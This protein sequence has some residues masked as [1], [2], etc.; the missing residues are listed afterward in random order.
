MN[1]LN[2]LTIYLTSIRLLND[3][4][5]SNDNFKWML[6]AVGNGFYLPTVSGERVY[7]AINR[8]I[9]HRDGNLIFAGWNMNDSTIDI[10][11]GW[12]S[13]E[14]WEKYCTPFIDPES[15]EDSE[16]RIS[17]TDFCKIVDYLGGVNIDLILSEPI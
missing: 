2:F 17:I 5:N 3:S 14:V 8:G 7:F 9:S 1:T 10:A 13:P 16:I 4:P 15:C 11:K 12:V 6:E